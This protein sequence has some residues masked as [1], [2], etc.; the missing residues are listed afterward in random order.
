MDGDLPWT[1]VTELTAFPQNPLAVLGA[2]SHSQWGGIGDMREM[3]GRGE[4]GERW[5]EGR[6]KMEEEG[7]KG[8]GLI[9]AC[10]I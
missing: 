6:R 1:L 2:A 5:K 7:S 3:K 10:I 9:G 4:E 8:R